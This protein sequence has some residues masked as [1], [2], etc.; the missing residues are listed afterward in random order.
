VSALRRKC[1]ATQG[2]P[3]QGRVLPCGRHAAKFGG[4]LVPRAT[5]C[6]ADAPVKFTALPLAG[7]PLEVAPRR[8]A[9]EEA[10]CVCGA[11]RLGSAFYGPPRAYLEQEATPEPRRAGRSSGSSLRG[12]PIPSH[13]RPWWLDT[14]LFSGRVEVAKNDANPRAS[15]IC[16]QLHRERVPGHS[17][18]AE[19]PQS[20]VLRTDRGDFCARAKGPAGSG[21]RPSGGCGADRGA[22]GV[23]LERVL[24]AASQGKSSEGSLSQAAEPSR[25][26][27]R[28]CSSK[29]GEATHHGA[30]PVSEEKVE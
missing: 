1:T 21:Q 25:A 9:G 2:F 19:G 10:A 23:V 14:P 3:N 26:R 5:R 6:R 8:Q 17:A 12:V 22:Q 20:G 4:A 11:S 13:L 27:H 29:R 7:L 24:A 16:R 30:E 18:V 28:L 15:E